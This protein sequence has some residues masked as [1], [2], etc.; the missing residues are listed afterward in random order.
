MAAG[1]GERR[2][3][4]KLWERCQQLSLMSQSDEIPE[5]GKERGGGKRETVN[6][7]RSEGSEEI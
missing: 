7:E 4:R 2:K 5:M 3:E 1:D 6:E